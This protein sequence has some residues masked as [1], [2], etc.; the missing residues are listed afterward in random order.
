MT[1]GLHRCERD[2]LSPTRLG[3]MVPGAAASPGAPC[4]QA[5]SGSE[6]RAWSWSGGRTPC[7]G[8]GHSR[9]VRGLRATPRSLVG[10]TAVGQW[11]ARG[12]RLFFIG[13]HRVEGGV[14][15]PC[16]GTGQPCSW[17]RGLRRPGHGPGSDPDP[18]PRSCSYQNGRSMLGADAVRPGECWAARPG[19]LD[20]RDALAREPRIRLAARGCCGGEPVCSAPGRGPEL[21]GGAARYME[22]GR[23]HAWKRLV[24]CAGPW[25]RRTREPVGLGTGRQPGGG[26]AFPAGG[27]G[28]EPGFGVRAAP[29][30][31]GGRRASVHQGKK[32]LEL[33]PGQ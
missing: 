19:C 3:W 21:P 4:P 15:V 8:S 26:R 24:L 25:A 11:Q 20:A 1:E 6:P 23:A 12:R 29:G 33:W 17:P 28:A 5:P 27:P 30:R 9:G 31:A 10:E 22:P 16:D 7:A 2:A 13:V 18:C 14:S 32:G